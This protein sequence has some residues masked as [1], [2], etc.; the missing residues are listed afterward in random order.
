MKNCLWPSQTRFRF[1]KNSNSYIKYCAKFIWFKFNDT[2]PTSY[3]ANLTHTT[4]AALCKFFN[5]FNSSKAKQKQKKTEKMSLTSKSEILLDNGNIRRWRCDDKNRY[6]QLSISWEWFYFSRKFTA[7]HF[8]H[9][10]QKSRRSAENIK[11][12]MHVKLAKRRQ[13]TSCRMLT[14]F[15]RHIAQY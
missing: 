11:S 2:I 14:Q 7:N 1:A 4:S 13:S 10:S 5:N 6:S 12:N 3:Q 15:R 8:Q 9:P